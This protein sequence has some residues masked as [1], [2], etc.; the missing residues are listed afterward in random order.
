MHRTRILFLILCFSSF[1]FFS[2]LNPRAC[3]PQ[4]S[5]HVLLDCF[6]YFFSC[7]A[8][9]VVWAG[10]QM[11]CG[12]SRVGLP[13]FWVFVSWS[14][15]KSV[16][17]INYACV[18][19]MLDR[20]LSEQSWNSLVKKKLFL[21]SS[22]AGYCSIS[23]SFVFFP[24]NPS[25]SRSLWWMGVGGS[26]E[27]SSSLCKARMFSFQVSCHHFWAP[28]F[29]KNSFVLLPSRFPISVSLFLPRTKVDNLKD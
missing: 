29:Y 3:S 16:A 18:S 11:G 23:L 7:R 13:I 20:A 24:H 6:P 9:S 22:G 15:G 8:M 27:S 14:H 10:R 21:P 25:S 4:L 12:L 1:P 19:H 17:V 5:F 2:F 28:F 26:Q